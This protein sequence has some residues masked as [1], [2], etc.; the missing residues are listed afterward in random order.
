M[1]AERQ[2]PLRFRQAVRV[3]H[4]LRGDELLRSGRG[5]HRARGELRAQHRKND[6]AT[7]FT[8]SLHWQDEQLICSY[9]NPSMGG[10]ACAAGAPASGSGSDDD[11]GDLGLALL[12][13]RQRRSRP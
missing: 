9:Q 2:L 4:R 10:A 3:L 5:H 12:A 1:R 8:G 11:G 6:G 7:A 13:L